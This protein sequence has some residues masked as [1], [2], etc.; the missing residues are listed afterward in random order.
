MERET[1]G[2]GAVRQGEELVISNLFHPFPNLPVLAYYLYLDYLDLYSS[3][4]NK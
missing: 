4:G 3:N 2:T 1:D